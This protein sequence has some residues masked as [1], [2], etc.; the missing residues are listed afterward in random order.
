MRATIFAGA[1]MLAAADLAS[2]DV[3]YDNLTGQP[4]HGTLVLPGQ[5][6]AQDVHLDPAGGLEIVGLSVRFRNTG[7]D[8]D[9][10]IITMSLYADGGGRP[11]DHL[12][13]YSQTYQ[14]PPGTM[15]IYYTSFAPFHSPTRDLWAAWRIESN[16]VLA[17]GVDYGGEPFIG[18]TTNQ[19]FTRSDGLGDWVDSGPWNADPFHIRVTAVPVPATSLCLLLLG[20]P[21]RR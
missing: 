12:V 8:H 11:G 2:A 15:G 17:I 19:Y 20:V 5:E 7:Q 9:T 1:L 16:G 21:R 18:T 4:T 6:I 10:G 3:A 13:S 14:M